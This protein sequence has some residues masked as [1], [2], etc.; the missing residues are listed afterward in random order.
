M[1]DYA[2]SKDNAKTLIKNFVESGVQPKFM[3][4]LDFKGCFVDAEFFGYGAEYV[5]SNFRIYV[6][7][8]GADQTEVIECSVYGRFNQIKSFCCACEG[9]DFIDEAKRQGVDFVM[10]E[11][12]LNLIKIEDKKDSLEVEYDKYSYYSRRASKSSN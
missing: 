3:E 6:A 9:R 7:V 5:V 1:I 4:Y 2:K 10:K 12:K 11:G 8:V